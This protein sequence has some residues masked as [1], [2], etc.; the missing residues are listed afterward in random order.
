MTSEACI[1]C[2]GWGKE[3]DMCRIGIPEDT[4]REPTTREDSIGELLFL[5]LVKDRL[6]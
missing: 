1:N 5:A 6:F 2:E 4:S 3:C